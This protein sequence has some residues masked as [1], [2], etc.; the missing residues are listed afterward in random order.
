MIAAFGAPNSNDSLG[1][2]AQDTANPANTQNM[3]YQHLMRAC[4]NLGY[5]TYDGGRVGIYYGG[6]NSPSNNTVCWIANPRPSSGSDITCQNA[7]TAGNPD[8]I[9]SFTCLCSP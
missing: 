8:Y 2:L 9:G 4:T 6:F 1:I 3:I 7:A 5:D